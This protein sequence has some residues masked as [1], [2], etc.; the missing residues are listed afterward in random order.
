MAML[1]HVHDQAEDIGQ[2]ASLKVQLRDLRDDMDLKEALLKSS[3]EAESRAAKD[4][5]VLREKFSLLEEDFSKKKEKA[6]GLGAK[7]LKLKDEVSHLRT[8]AAED[9]SALSLL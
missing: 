5:A 3:K 7:N 2:A 8:K 6:V 9:G 1:Q 4:L